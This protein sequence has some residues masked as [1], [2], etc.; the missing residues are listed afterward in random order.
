VGAEVVPSSA[1]VTRC[2]VHLGV[3]GAVERLKKIAAPLQETAKR[4]FLR[5]NE[6]RGCSWR[7]SHHRL[8][9]I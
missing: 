6:K 4:R 2:A 9:R 5:T 1:A 7:A 3:A 8:Q